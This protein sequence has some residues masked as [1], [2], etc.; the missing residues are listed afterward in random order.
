MRIIMRMGNVAGMRKIRRR[1][2]HR[3]RRKR[4]RF[5]SIGRATVKGP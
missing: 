3:K 5:E 2:G 4:G 1:K